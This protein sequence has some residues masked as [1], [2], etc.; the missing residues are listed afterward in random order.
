MFSTRWR[1]VV[2]ELWSN[3][4]RTV[5][6][7]ASIAV[8]IFA[9][10]TVQLLNSVIQS[11]L[12]VIYAES[13]LS[14]ATIITS[15]VD[16]EQLDAIR[17]MRDV[18][19]VQ[20][21]STLALKVQTAPD[22][23]ETLSVTAIDDF[24]DIRINRIQP[25]Y[26]LPAKPEVGA[27]RT[28]WPGKD[29]IVIER[30]GLRSATALPP[31][32]QVGQKLT[33][34]NRDDR[35][36][37]V[38]LSGIVYDP[39]GFSAN[40]SG[41][42]TGYVDFATFERLGGERV[43]Q[44]VLIRVKGTPDQLLNKEY[45][46]AI[47]NEVADKIEKGGY[48]VARVQVA[49]PGKLAL[50]DLF[51]ALALLL[52]PLG[53]LALILS[54]FLVINTISALMAQQVRQIGV[55][56][57]VGARRYQLFGMYLG[58]VLVYSLAALAVAVPITVVAGGGIASFL[59]TFINIDFP[60]WSLPPNVFAIQLLVGLLTPMLAA[61]VPIF[62]GTGMTVREAV[63]DYGTNAEQVRDGWLTRAINSVRGLS[64]P[65]Q[66]S[67]RNTFRRR[68]RLALTLITLTLGGMLFMTVGSVRSSLNGLIEQ[69]LDYYQ[70]DVQIQ[71]EQPYRT[72]RVEQVVRSLP[73]VAIVEGWLGAQATPILP[74]GSDGDT[75]TLTALESNSAMVQPTL[76]DGRW[77]LP[78]D[79]NAVVISQNV[80][81]SQPGLKPGDSMQLKIGAKEYEF[82][83]VG[84]ARVLGGPP[85]V[86]PAY[87]NYPY[88]A[89]LTA[90]VNRASSL[91]IKLDPASGLQMEDAAKILNERLEASG[92]DVASTFT[93]DTLRRFTGAFFDIIVY[94]LLAMGVLIASVG[95]LGLAGTMSTNVL[96]RTREIGVMRAIGASDG[97]VLRIVIVE[98]II[99]GL[100][101]WG[102]GA[103]LAWPVGALLAQTVGV[104]LF[105]SALPYIF[106]S[107]GLAAWLAIVVVLATVASFLPAWK[108]SRLTVREVLAY[109]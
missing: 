86:I 24:D 59:G 52:T 92:Y 69:G 56:K 36:R 55:M 75:L 99:I 22:K 45:I 18:A 26:E 73:G 8:G 57:A 42:A 54:S 87:V 95:A 37:E 35:P 33:L 77:L 88:F 108:A 60:R 14:Q 27:E 7:I 76:T 61:L 13:N 98:G 71:F 101:S 104:V 40:F 105:Q 9:V 93:I 16:A 68:G 5:L 109:Q 51:D 79:E 15:G 64:R 12:K 44:Q 89:R 41:Q 96:E 80:L 58:A 67:L 83:V 46:T 53:L 2:R 23:Q 63:S 48:T 6:V 103:L 85:N 10:G 49:E 34:Q 81:A 17:R 84:V 28:V 30:S 70:F 74:D 90:D 1:K 31:G 62:K 21:R 97:S 91:Q 43:Y 100:I 107:G 3:R 38:T 102:I 106:S 66:L 72:Q 32:L 20:G 4:T 47:A 11:E 29:E 50:Q 82:V 25:L 65:M 94:L 78:D 19:D 39:N